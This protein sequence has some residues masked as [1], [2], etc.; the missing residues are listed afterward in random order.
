MFIA[1]YPQVLVYYA[2]YTEISIIHRRWKLGG[3]G[4]GGVED[5]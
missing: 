1:I 5:H 3:E 2:E 4:G